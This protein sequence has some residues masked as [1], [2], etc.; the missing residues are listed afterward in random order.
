M[1]K[2]KWLSGI[3]AAV[4]A[5]GLLAG[6]ADGKTGAVVEGLETEQQENSMGQEASGKKGRFLETEVVLPG[7][8][9]TIYCMGKQENGAVSVFAG[10]E[11]KDYLFTSWDMGESWDTV[12]TDLSDSWIM[13]SGIA[14]D[15]SAYLAGYFEDIANMEQCAVK[16][17]APDGTVTD[18]ILNLPEMGNSDVFQMDSTETGENAFNNTVCQLEVTY[19][20]EILIQDL[21]GDILKV[22]LETGECTKAVGYEGDVSYFGLAGEKL[23]LVTDNGI[24]VYHVE[25]GTAYPADEVLNTIVLTDASAAQKASDRAYPMLFTEGIE[26]GSIVYANHSGVYYHRDGGSIAEQL[27]NGELNSLGDT[28]ISFYSMVML[29]ETNFLLQIAD[30]TGNEKIL[31]YSYDKTV[32]AVPEKELTLYSLEDS[33]I[34]RQ[35]VSIYQKQ[36][37]DIYVKLE[38]G[39]S[40]ED[41]ITAEDAI[42]A[43]NTEIMAGNAPDV[44]ILDGLPTESYIEKGIL[45]DISGVVKQLE[46][47]DGLFSNIREC[48]ERDGAYYELPARFYTSLVYGTPDAVAAGVSLEAFADYVEQLQEADPDHAQIQSKT[49]QNLLWTLYQADSANWRKKDGTLDEEK[50]K[51]WLTQAKRLYD[52]DPDGEE[53]FERYI[54]QNELVGTISTGAIAILMDEA[55]IGYG[56]LVGLTNLVDLLA[57]GERTGY[58]YSILNGQEK[59]SFSPYLKAGISSTS[60]V[61]EEAEEFLLTLFGKE[62]G[63]ADGN[64]FPINRAGFDALCE[65]GLELYGSESQVSIAVSTS[66]GE[67]VGYVMN[68]LNETVTDSFA[69]FLESLNSPA[70]EDATVENIVLTWGENYLK[71]RFS[72][73]ETLSNI[74]QKLNLYLAE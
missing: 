13:G 66:T 39:M 8:V 30:V 38:I 26:K 63:G 58:D 1:K 7:E 9:E 56:T 69:A 19:A 44:M 71:G 60:D 28:S 11:E 53:S 70:I 72:L 46:E 14:P 73:E 67:P 17:V 22:N 2:R 21:N 4:L 42:A 31:I 35:A 5:A 37:Q 24:P 36:N 32:S 50:I 40:G 59:K 64:G 51:N 57:V 61:S 15:G 27:V 62:C 74:T 48:Y 43:L 12:E 29:D 54:Y 52:C 20:G 18:F 45:A 3:L 33:S 25:N 55:D 68:Q 6:C 47:T 10:G 16:K 41:G 23:L 34:L 49:A 65:R